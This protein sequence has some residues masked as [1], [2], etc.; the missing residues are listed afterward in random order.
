MYHWRFQAKHAM[1]IMNR[2]FAAALLGAVVSTLAGCGGGGSGD[3]APAQTVTPKTVLIETYGDST[4]QG[5]EGIGNGNGFLTTANEP[6]MLQAALQAR[7][8]SVVTVSNQ[9]VGGTEASQLLNGTDGVHPSWPTQMANS[10]A[11]I[12]T[13]N[14]SLN[15]SYYTQVSKAGV[16]PESLTDYA[17]NLTQLIQIAK[18]AGKQVVLFE[19]N[20]TCEPIRQ[21]LMPSYVGAL[22]GVASSQNV[23][24]VYEYDQYLALPNWQTAYLTDC[25]HPND[26]G[27]ATKANWEAPVVAQIVGPLLQ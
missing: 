13:L 10:K 8:G 18:A 11:Q 5:W 19:P 9:G 4:T 3:P 21:P 16:A 22:R 23:P 12:V 17:A 15:D 1:K 14:F 7:F 27:Y 24:L 20:A 26:A 2:G 6:V 25:L